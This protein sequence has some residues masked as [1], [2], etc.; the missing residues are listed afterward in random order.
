[1][2]SH[3]RHVTREA[4][5]R[6]LFQIDA[7]RTVDLLIDV[8]HDADVQVRAAADAMTSASQVWLMF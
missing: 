5:V 2:L 7:D 6:A 1:M 8:L 4:A 3:P